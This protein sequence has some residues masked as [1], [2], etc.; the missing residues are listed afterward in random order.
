MSYIVEHYFTA[1]NGLTCYVILSNA[2]F[3]CGYVEAPPTLVNFPYYESNIHLEDITPFTYILTPI[4][5]AINN[6]DVH[7]GVTFSG[8]LEFSSAY[9]FGFDCKHY[10]D[11]PDLAALEANKDKFDTI[12]TTNTYNKDRTV[13]TLDFVISECISLAN[14]LYSIHLLAEQI[15]SKHPEAF[16]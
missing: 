8:N 5:L 1:D 6:I 7:G 14:Q 12:D 13:R 11:A 4:Q 3:R 10:L 9:L 16:L 2:G 15:K